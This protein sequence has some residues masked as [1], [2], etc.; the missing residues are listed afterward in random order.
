MNIVIAM[1]SFKGSL[2]SLE[3]ADAVREGILRAHPEASI[4]VLPL[5]DGGEGTVDALIAGLG[6]ERVYAEVSGPLGESVQT[7]S[8]QVLSTE[9]VGEI[10]VAVEH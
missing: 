9:V 3:A 6:A 8:S 2:S 7:E 4:T 1:D 5:A 10:Q